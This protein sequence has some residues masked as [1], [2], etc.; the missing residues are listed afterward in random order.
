MKLKVI[1]CVLFVLF[2]VLSAA[3]SS[4][5][6]WRHH[7][8]LAHRHGWYRPRAVVEAYHAPVVMERYEGGYYRHHHY[9]GRRYMG[10]KSYDGYKRWK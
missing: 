4:A 7:H 9:Y 6:P 1:S 2:L 3:S 8:R 10:R 5:G